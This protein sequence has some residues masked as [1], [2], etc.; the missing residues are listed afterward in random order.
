MGHHAALNSTD[1]LL[2]SIKK[3]NPICCQQ[4]CIK[5]LL[6]NEEQLLLF[7]EEWGQLNQSQREVVL[8][9]TI[10]H[11]SHWSTHT[12][13]GSVRNLSR[14]E[15]EDPLLGRLC[16]KAFAALIGVGEATLSRHVA[17]VHAS[18]GGF[19]PSLHKN[20]GQPAR[21]PL[22]SS[23]RSEVINFLLEIV[24]LAG[25]ESSER[26]SFRSEGRKS[27]STSI[28]LNAEES[29]LV[30]LPSM[31]SLR[32][33]YHLYEE[34]IRVG[35]F[36][37]TYH[38]SWRSFHRI[39]HS[40][41]LSWLRIR[42]PRDDVCDVCLLYR[43]KMLNFLKKEETQRVLEK[44]GE[45]SHEL[46]SHRDLAMATRQV[47]RSE[48]KKALAGGKKIQE[49]LANKASRKKIT[50]LLLEHEAHYSFDFSQ[51]LWL[52][53]MAD[54]PGTFYFLSLRSINL[55]GIVDDGGNGDPLQ[56][57]LLYDQTTAGKGSSEVVSMLYYFLVHVRGHE[58]ASR[59]VYF[60]ADN[61][62]G[63]NK[64][65]T[66]IHFFLWCIA[67]GLVDHIEL[68]FLLKGHTKFSPDG[69]FGLIKKRYRMANV[70]T[71]EQVSDEIKQS[72]RKTDR[73]HAI[74]LEKT[75]FGNW[76][77]ALEKF[78]VTL[79][80]ISTFSV[81]VFDKKY[82]L[83]ELHTRKYE[84]KKFQ[85]H[86][87]LR[88]TSLSNKKLNNSEF[89]KLNNHLEPLEEP[90][91]QAK[92]QW[93]LYEKVRPFVPTEYQDLICPQPNVDKKDS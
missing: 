56:T 55:F 88:S 10:R 93:D 15:F 68:K 78:F 82:P 50:K 16:R 32:L 12:V 42:P 57:N 64:N 85:V 41:E 7:L 33:L 83:G 48:C 80:G 86:N 77:S 4:E 19:V 36:P 89:M 81:F 43:R 3:K 53:Q 71:M 18:K 21:R 38:L 30:F 92:K 40:K 26:H 9:F 8:R 37:K 76:K 74:V 54:T 91:I 79:K 62:V 84:D 58:F 66:M 70:Y 44:M 20:T 67:V 61:C 5:R 31:Y 72:T 47:Y 28:D 6:E 52:P 51:S 34:K 13:R 46:V 35:K 24:S 14:F 45:V 69:G 17:V 23:V 60:H 87:L 2:L 29:P 49:S 25:E 59:R 90:Q 39:F 22:E 75:D 11:C 73:N 65:N 63:Q 27:S 1:T